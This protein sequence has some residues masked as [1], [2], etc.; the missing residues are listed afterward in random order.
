MTGVAAVANLC[1]TQCGTGPLASLAH[2]LAGHRRPLRIGRYRVVINYTHRANLAI[3]YERR[4]RSN[5]ASLQPVAE[6]TSP[7]GFSSELGVRPLA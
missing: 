7:S 2:Y 5:K 3:A 4:A 6:A 1:R